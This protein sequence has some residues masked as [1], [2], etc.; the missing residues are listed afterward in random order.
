MDVLWAIKDGYKR[1]RAAH[2]NE[3]FGFRTLRDCMGATLLSGW[4]SI[5]WGCFIHVMSSSPSKLSGKPSPFHS[6]FLFA[7]LFSYLIC[8]FPARKFCRQF[9]ALDSLIY[10]PTW[11]NLLKKEKFF[12]MKTGEKKQIQSLWGQWDWIQTHADHSVQFT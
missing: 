8:L 2:V 7:A 9:K 11:K 12:W 4:Q 6:H 3:A 1:K 10:H 5:C